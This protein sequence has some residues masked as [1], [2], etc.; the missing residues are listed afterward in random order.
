MEIKDEREG[1]DGGK[2]IVVDE[3]GKWRSKVAIGR[4]NKTLSLLI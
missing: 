3:D 4:E 1:M 2:M